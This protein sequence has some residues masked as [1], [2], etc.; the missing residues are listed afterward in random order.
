MLEI[1]LQA[2]L[3]TVCLQVVMG[4]APSG[5]KTPYITWQHIGGDP[6]V[7]LDN[8]QADKRE[9][10]EALSVTDAVQALYKLLDPKEQARIKA[11]EDAQKA[12][13]TGGT[14]A[15]PPTYTG[16]GT[17]GGTVTGSSNRVTV[18]G[19]TA[20][21]R[22]IYSDGTTGKTA[23][24]EYTYNETGSM[25]SNG[26]SLAEFERFKTSGEFEWDAAKNQWVRR[27]SFDIGTNYVP[28]DMTAN[29]HKGGAGCDD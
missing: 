20:D 1:D 11:E 13:L 27:A 12:G 25:N 14:K 16:G 26:Y 8:T 15:P 19:L 5:T 28:Y 21:G 4:V 6:L 22:A 23:A 7:F 18:I 3:K 17:L 29:I 2:V 10:E 9:Q 24:G